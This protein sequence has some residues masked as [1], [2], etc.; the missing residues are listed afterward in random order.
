M[1]EAIC[2]LY[3]TVH[4]S[5]ILRSPV[6]VGSLS[7]YLQGFLH[8]RWCRISEPSTVSCQVRI[9]I[10]SPWF[11]LTVLDTRRASEKQRSSIGPFKI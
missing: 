6:E 1:V 4:G 2:T 5:E 7:R 8:P 9:R 10:V 11:D 3:H